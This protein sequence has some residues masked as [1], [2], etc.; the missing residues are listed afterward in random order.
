ME[1][2]PVEYSQTRTFDVEINGT[3]LAFISKLGIPDWNVVSPAQ[4]LICE[5]VHIEAGASV[6]L[7]GS[8]HGAAL[9]YLALKQPQLKIFALDSN[10]IALQMTEKTLQANKIGLDNVTLLYNPLLPGEFH[11]KF[12]L[13]VI[14]L[15]K[16]R[17]LAQKWL[18]DAFSYLKPGGKLYVTGVNDEGVNPILKDASCIFSKPV[19]LDYKKGNRI[20]LLKK[21]VESIPC[22]AWV[23][24]PG[25]RPDSWGEFEF[26]IGNARGRIRSLP[27]VFSAGELDPATKIL[28]ENLPPVSGKQVLDL[29]CG[30]GVIGIVCALRGA[31]VHMLD[32]N[33]YAIKSAEEN[34]ILNQAPNAS[35]FAGDGVGAV[36][37][38]RY[39][40]VFTNPPFHIGKPTDYGVTGT[41]IAQTSQILEPG[42]AL[43]LVSN[44]FIRYEKIMRDYF[45]EVS[46][47]FTDNKYQLLRAVKQRG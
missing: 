14:N 41:F 31:Q 7:M 27:G 35:V 13:V 22:V 28:L 44:R 5:H 34:V 8:G 38:N 32:S 9:S 20:A 29:G 39:D 16:G 26:E 47:L 18:F 43:I 40:F 45:S 25:V 12:D 17:R 42:G 6:L 10:F 15:P 19:I 3:R 24:Q 21:E 11:N 23:D 4:R 33:L 46:F 1:Q 2:T 30:S 37:H 36:L